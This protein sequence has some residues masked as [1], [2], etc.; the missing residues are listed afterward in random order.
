M[1]NVYAY[2]YIYYIYIHTHTRAYSVI[3]CA[4]LLSKKTT[5]GIRRLFSESPFGAADMGNCSVVSSHPDR[6]RW[7]SPYETS[8]IFGAKIINK[9][10]PNMVE[11]CWNTC[12]KPPN[13]YNQAVN[14]WLNHLQTVFW[15]PPAEQDAP[16]A[17]ELS[18]APAPLTPA[19]KT[20]AH[21]DPM[22]QLM[23]LKFYSDHH[24]SPMPMVCNV[25]AKSYAWNPINNGMF[26]TYQQVQDFAGP[27]TVWHPVPNSDRH[28]AQ[29]SLP[30]GWHTTK[31]LTLWWHFSHPKHQ[32]T[33]WWQSNCINM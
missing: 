21:R 8:G 22:S 5:P 10:S 14:V 27:S 17:L 30:P 1:I 32:M 11:T 23:G 12:S 16:S 6:A 4:V 20:S 31:T 2:I 15:S 9:I 19:H 13:N 29:I 25:D 28:D 33:Q 18:S 3:M 24:C 26:T 7:F